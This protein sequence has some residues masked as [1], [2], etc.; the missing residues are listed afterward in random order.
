MHTV[1]KGAMLTGV[2]AMGLSFAA[3]DSKQEN[4]AEDRA[5]KIDKK[6]G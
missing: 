5:D 1:L 4:A 3:C 6:P 2:A